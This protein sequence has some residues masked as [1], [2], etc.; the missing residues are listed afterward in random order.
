MNL[1]NYITP[2]PMEDLDGINIFDDHYVPINVTNSHG[3][4][5]PCSIIRIIN[6]TD[7][8]LIISLDGI[9]THDHFW[10]GSGQT[11][12]INTQVNNMVPN[13]VAQF[14]KGT[15]FYVKNDDVLNQPVG[16][17]S[18]AGYSSYRN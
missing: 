12:Q 3:L 13:N 5:L 1:K 9:L 11:L 7:Q 2:V 4:P 17:I 18:V 10:I 14:A 8:H 15:V 16:F 6:Y